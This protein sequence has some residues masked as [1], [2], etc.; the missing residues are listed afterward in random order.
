MGT[1]MSRHEHDSITHKFVGNGDGLLGITG[2]IGD[3]QFDSLSEDTA[4]VVDVVDSHFSTVLDL[5][6]S[7]DVRSGERA[8][9]GDQN[10]CTPGCHAR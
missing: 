7:E 5:F 10:V 8:R 2:V 1:D 6:T 3:Q 9:G 4:P